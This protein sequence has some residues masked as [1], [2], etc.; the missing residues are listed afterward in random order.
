MEYNS[1]APKIDITKSVKL[2]QYYNE[3]NLSPE[4][5]AFVSDVNIGVLFDESTYN[6]IEYKTKTYKAMKESVASGKVSSE[7]VE[8]EMEALRADVLYES[9]GQDIETLDLSSLKSVERLDEILRESGASSKND[10]RVKL[11]DIPENWTS[12]E[13]QKVEI[14]SSNEPF[15]YGILPSAK[16]VVLSDGTIITKANSLYRK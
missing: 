13:F 2:E 5:T 10:I 8:Q 16:M 15:S 7:Q 4:D 12:S 9:N 14:V 1:L 11:C 3:Q 6:S